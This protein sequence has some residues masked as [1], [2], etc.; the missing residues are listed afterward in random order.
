MGVRNNIL[1][2]SDY[3]DDEIIEAVDENDTNDAILEY[4]RN[5][6]GSSAV[7]TAQSFFETLKYAGDV[8]NEDLLIADIFTDADGAKDTIST[9]DSSADYID[10]IDSYQL[11]TNID[12]SFFGVTLLLV[13]FD[14]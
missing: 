10:T 13:F 11:S 6:V 5:F 14:I 9:G 2:G 7:A 3:V 12:I 4:V 1:G 8:D